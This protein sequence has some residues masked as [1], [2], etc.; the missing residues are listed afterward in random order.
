M[1]SIFA[2]AVLLGLSLFAVAGAEARTQSSQPSAKCQA[3]MKQLNQL[4]DKIEATCQ[5]DRE[6]MPVPGNPACD[7]LIKQADDL[8][9]QFEAE[10]CLPEDNAG[11]D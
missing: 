5:F 8:H 4:F 7:A 10:K 11:S 2:L 3:L 6:D 9:P 1:K